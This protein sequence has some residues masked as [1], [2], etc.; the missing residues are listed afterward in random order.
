MSSRLACWEEGRTTGWPGLEWQNQYRT[1]QLGISSYSDILLAV[2]YKR[3]WLWTEI[4]R[5][6]TRINSCSNCILLG[7]TNWKSKYQN[8]HIAKAWILVTIAMRY[9][10]VDSLT[11]DGYKHDLDRSHVDIELYN[12]FLY[13][14]ISSHYSSSVVSS[15]VVSASLGI[16]CLVC[17]F[18]SFGCSKPTKFC[19]TSTCGPLKMIWK[20]TLSGYS[21]GGSS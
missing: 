12:C 17:L 10:N 20:S 2:N 16:W 7:V 9:N 5:C 13:W 18:T 4:C 8:K 6:F 11:V 19:K 14:Q 15:S 21:T 1:E 3:W